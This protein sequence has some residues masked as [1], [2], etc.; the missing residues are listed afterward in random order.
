V[1]NWDEDGFSEYNCNSCN[2]ADIRIKANL[3]CPFV[4]SK[5]KTTQ[6]LSVKTCPG[7]YFS[8]PGTWELQEIKNNAPNWGD[9]FYKSYLITDVIDSFRKIESLKASLKLRAERKN[10]T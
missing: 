6:A 8:Q 7:W 4:D 9:L 10:G 2:L 1:Y 5:H 3:G